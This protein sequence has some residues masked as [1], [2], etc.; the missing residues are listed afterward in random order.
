E[1][2]LLQR[3]AWERQQ[4][5]QDGLQE[6]LSRLRDANRQLTQDLEQA[7]RRLDAEEKKARRYQER[8]RQLADALKAIHRALFEGNLFSLILKAC[9][10][11]TGA[12]RGLYV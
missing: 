5:L 3:A 11:V 4:A 9:L 10:T 6:Q 1:N 8:A 12:T 7:R 2:Y